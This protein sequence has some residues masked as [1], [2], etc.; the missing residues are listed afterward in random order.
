MAAEQSN[1]AGRLAASAAHPPVHERVSLI[2]PRRTDLRYALA[3][4]WRYRRFMLYFGG[5][6]VRKRYMRTWLGRAWLPLRPA[7]NVGTK[8][9]VFGGLVGISAGKTPYPLFLLTA[10][11]AWQLFSESIVWSTR[12][13]YLSRNQLR[14][15]H[16]PR[17]VV[18]ISSVI[19]TLVDFLMALSL[20]AVAFV[21]YLLRSHT[22]FLTLSWRSPVYVAGGLLALLLLGVGMGVAGAVAGTR[23]RDVR[24][25][26]GYIVGFFYYLTPIIY[27]FQQIPN[28]YKP[29]AELNPLTGAMELFK[30]GL[31]ATPTPSPEA[32][33]V[34]ALALFLIWGPGLVLFHRREVREW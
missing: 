18:I 13:L 17:L 22:L 7:L 6:F 15:L 34:T 28:T 31:F 4:L 20:A 25:I 2:E 30:A 8:L 12:S 32:L 27:S 33:G 23:A 16:V 21:Y 19:P 5:S 11:A 24:F 14:V 29:L 26:L 3:E 9:L 10:T 1:T